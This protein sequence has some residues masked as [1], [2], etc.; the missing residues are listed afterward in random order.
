M[1]KG[2]LLSICCW[3]F[4][5]VTSLIW[6]LSQ[7]RQQYQ[8]L[9]ASSA[10]SFFQQILITREWAANHG[11]VYAPVT[12]A[13]PP[14]PYLN[15][16]MRDLQI[17]PDLELTKINPAYMTR[18]IAEIADSRK[19]IS[20]HIT[21]LKPIRPQNAA[22]DWETRALQ[23]FEKGLPEK[24]EFVPSGDHMTY[25]YMAPLL[26]EQSCLSCHSDHK[27]GDIRGGIGVTIPVTDN[28]SSKPLYIGHFILGI[29]GIVGISV[30][31]TVL[32]RT[33]SKM[34]R[35]AVIDSL[36]GVANRRS[37]SERVVEEFSRCTRDNV[38]LSVLMCDIDNFKLYNDT[39][40]H[41]AG[42]KCLTVVAGIMKNSIRRPTDFCARYGGEEFILILP[43]TSPA[44]SIRVA[45]TILEN[46]RQMRLA[47][48][49]SPCGYVTLSI[50][51]ATALGQGISSHEELVRHADSA[52][53]DAKKNGKDRF[54]V[55]REGNTV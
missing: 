16:P 8:N 22:N 46:I 2:A 31:W 55:Y 54:E 1:K 27:V 47:H 44:G 45:E 50:G 25:V 12:E 15:T 36:T 3:L 4:I 13:T 32:N 9:A 49:K 38:P 51:T 43:N 52:L 18:Q 42:D 40:G 41:S 14:N 10:R 33:Y 17:S 48:E 26:T 34:H 19:G 21:S 6:N 29:I 24:G 23:E 20:F 39:Y 37:F 11:G 7:S 53:Y 28:A 5:V 30:F 35:L